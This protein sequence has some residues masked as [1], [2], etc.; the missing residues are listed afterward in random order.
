VRQKLLSSALRPQHDGLRNPVST[1]RD[2]HPLLLLRTLAVMDQQTIKNAKGV[3]IAAGLYRPARFVVDHVF[4]RVRL[5]ERRRRLNFYRQLIAPGELC[6]DVGANIGDYTD[7]LLSLGARVVAVEPQPSCI[8]E[9]RA[10]FVGHDFATVVPIALGEA[11]GTARLFLREHTMLASLIEDW[12]GRRNLGAVEVPIKTLDQL[13]R[14]YGHP[15]Y[16]KIDVEG[17]ELPV[18]RG[19]HSKV[20]LISFEYHPQPKDW[21]EKLQIIELL[22]KLGDL[23]LAILCEGAAEWTIGW[24]KI[25]DFL[26]IV[27]EQ[28]PPL[29]GD[30]FCRLL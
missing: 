22:R 11:E 4:H 3:L 19:L 23:E 5:H 1:R 28:I 20:E 30:V 24:T 14:T 10:R 29:I 15:K 6:F 7:T 25:G 26:K 17:Y 12:D 21:A 16:I 2:W 27:P 18:V 13:I 8:E 9:L